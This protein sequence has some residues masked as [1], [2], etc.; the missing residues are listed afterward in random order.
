[1]ANEI[2]YGGLIHLQNGY[3]NWAGGYLDTNGHRPAPAK[4]GVSTADTPTRGAGTGTWE[5]LSATGKAAGSLVNSGDVIYLRN[6]YQDDGGYLDTNGHASDAQKQSGG[7]YDVST[8]PGRDRAQGT[9]RWR[10]LAQTS[11]TLDQSVR[12]GDVLLLWNLYDNGSFLET[13]S[14]SGAGLYDVCTNAYFNRAAD[15]AYWKALAAQV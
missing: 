2:R 3:N 12:L 15:V 14:T 4:Y 6:L 11:G 8:S 9:G 13:N 5:V 7:K 10:I 1:M